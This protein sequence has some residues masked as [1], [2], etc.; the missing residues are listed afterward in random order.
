[1]TVVDRAPNVE[2]TVTVIPMRA[3]TA[4]LSI[5]WTPIDPAAEPYLQRIAVASR[6]PSRDVEGVAFSCKKRGAAVVDDQ[7]P[8]NSASLTVPLPSSFV[9]LL[10]F[11]R[12]VLTAFVRI[13]FAAIRARHRAWL[14]RRV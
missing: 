11:A 14:A 7:Y 6:C 2:L 3:G 13:F 10:P 8:I 1:V 9:R 12:R 5:W 4:P